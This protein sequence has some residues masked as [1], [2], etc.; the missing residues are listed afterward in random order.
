M[1]INVLGWNVKCDAW[2]NIL[3]NQCQD[4]CQ[5]TQ[6]MHNVKKLQIPESGYLTP[7]LAAWLGNFILTSSHKLFF[8]L[9]IF[10]AIRES[11]SVISSS[12]ITPQ[13]MS[14]IRMNTRWERHWWCS[15]FIV[16]SRYYVVTAGPVESW[17]LIRPNQETRMTHIS[18]QGVHTGLA[19]E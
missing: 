9:R 15:W 1:L 6:E 4:E 11:P 7:A 8:Q 3:D 16:R 14:H 5:S 19:D 18:M 13:L 12:V 10:S 17:S 2:K